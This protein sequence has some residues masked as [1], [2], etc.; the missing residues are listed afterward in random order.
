MHAVDVL[1]TLVA[2]ATGLRGV[3]LLMQSMAL[4]QRPLDGITHTFHTMQKRRNPLA[5]VSDYH[6]ACAVM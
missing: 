1:P 4:D 2:A 3:D 6:F 5:R